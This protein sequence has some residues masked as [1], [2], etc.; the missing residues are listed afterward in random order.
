LTRFPHLTAVAVAS[1]TTALFIAVSQ[2]ALSNYVRI[3]DFLRFRLAVNA[4]NGHGFAF[5]PD[6]LHLN[7]LTPL[8]ALIDALL[9][10]PVTFFTEP[11]P[12]DVARLVIIATTAL[13]TGFLA[14][15]L[16]KLLQ[17]NLTSGWALL[18]VVGL[19]LS[20]PLWFNMRSGALLAAG[21]ILLALLVGERGRWG[22]AGLLAGLGAAS[23]PGGIAGA[24]ALGIYSTRHENGLR[25]WRWVWVPLAA[26]LGFAALYTEGDWIQGLLVQQLVTTGD[27]VQN[28]AWLG[29]FV[30]IAAA[31]SRVEAPP[32]LWMLGLWTALELGAK[33]LVYGEL[34]QVDSL[35]LVLF[36]AAGLVVLSTQ[37]QVAIAG[38]AMVIL[39]AL[40][41][42]FPLQ[43][44]AELQ[45]D[46]D[47]SNSIHIDP[48][49]DLLHDRTHGIVFYLEEFSGNSYAWDGDRSVTVQ[50]FRSRDDYT[51]LIIRTAPDFIY[52]NDATLDAAGLNLRSDE[53]QPLNY[54]REIDV[55][56]DPGQREGDGFWFRNSEVV[57]FGDTVTLDERLTPDIILSS[58]ATD[59]QRLIPGEP[60]R[61]RLDWELDRAPE[62]NIGLQ[63]NV[64]DRNGVPIVSSFPAYAAAQWEADAFSTYHALSIPEDA[65]PQVVNISVAIDYRAAII[66]RSTV[67]ETSIQPPPVE[68]PETPVGQIASVTV[69]AADIIPTEDA[70]HIEVLWETSAELPRDYQVLMHLVPVGDVQPVATGDAPPVGGSYPTSAWRP[71]DVITDNYRVPLTDVPPG[72]YQLNTGFYLLDTFER[73]RDENGDSLVIARIIVEE[74]GSVKVR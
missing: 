12:T 18:G 74:D 7:T 40:W 6:H 17:Q 5:N 1:A 26:W 8:P 65:P 53:L 38:V 13:A 21:W 20:Q 37:V 70:L 73:L 63:I 61:L 31:V 35:A 68:V 47:L 50:N 16:Y 52:I 67:T 69:H 15:Q 30:L 72:E 46:L 60:I 49:N 43:T 56:L 57:P 55:Q 2:L 39:V 45:R 33:V 9:L 51:A 25:F 14:V 11:V 64:I 44:S 24:L 34:T 66:G 36:I 29:G 27:D 32:W 10:Y 3:E 42:V 23:A 58:Y 54:R 62:D 41:V 4:S 19:L 28:L 22:R 48:N 59:H 71:G